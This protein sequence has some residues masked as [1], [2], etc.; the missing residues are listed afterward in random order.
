MT[1]EMISAQLDEQEAE[2]EAGKLQIE[3]A[4]KQIEQSKDV[5]EKKMTSKELSE[6]MEQDIKDLRIC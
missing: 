2:I 5:Y 3:E 6:V 1:E 4:K